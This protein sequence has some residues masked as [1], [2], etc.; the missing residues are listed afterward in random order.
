[1]S[2]EI[3]YR[4]ANKQLDEVLFNVAE[5]EVFV[6]LLEEEN[7]FDAKSKHKKVDGYK[8]LFN[9]KKKEV[10]SIVSRNYKVVSNI[11]A[12]EIGKEAFKTLFPSIDTND[13]I[14]FKV[15]A[16]KKLTTCHI[17]LI[18]KEVKLHKWDQDTW[19]PFIRVS[20]S[21]NRSI[22]L[23][24]EFGFV[25]TLCSNGCVFNKD[26]VKVKYNHTNDLKSF[27]IH[28]DVSKLKKHE[29]EFANYLNELNRFHVNKKY[30]I[31]LVLKALN[32]NFGVIQ[33]SDNLKE[34][35]EYSRYKKAKGTIGSI[36]DKY[37]DELEPTAYAILNIITD[38]VSHNADYG[39]I[40]FYQANVNRYYNK[41][42]EWTKDFVS[43][44]QK[45]G[46]KME[47]YLGDF[48]KYLN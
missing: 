20:N 3:D 25:R 45:K 15:I 46:F 22:A 11:E 36:T 12:L 19:L 16:T 2:R 6:E 17:D 27:N 30:A 23:T 41:S 26:T 28:A 47:N 33:P 1:M 9:N 48:T 4:P 7:I 42:G 37:Y 24:L 13:L 21:F 8:A 34:L 38:I 31:P 29:I 40:P 32:M 10:L 39:I 14:P 44:I 43:A 35:R 18:H 5:K